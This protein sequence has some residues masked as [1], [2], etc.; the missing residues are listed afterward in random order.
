[1]P[2][3]PTLIL[4]DDLVADLRTRWDP[5][6]NEGGIERV[7]FKTLAGADRVTK[8]PGRRVLILPYGDDGAFYD[9]GPSDR[10]E[11]VYTHNISVVIS[12]RFTDAGEPTTEWIDDRVDFVHENIVQGFD[13]SHDGPPSWNKKLTTLTTKTVVDW[14]RL[15]SEEQAFYSWVVLVFEEIR[16]A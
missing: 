9:N 6:G 3:T 10:G 14:A 11:D 2:T 8:L 13:F 4:C 16:D 7:Y 15:T 5:P 12:E 1:M